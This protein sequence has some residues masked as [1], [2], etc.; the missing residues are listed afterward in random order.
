MPNAKANLSVRCTLK[1][2]RRFFPY[3]YFGALHLN[4]NF[5][6]CVGHLAAQ[7]LL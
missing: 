2:V 5:Q 3:K 6:S 7:H 4:L 1:R